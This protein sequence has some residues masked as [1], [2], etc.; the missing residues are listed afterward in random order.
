VV[1]NSLPLFPLG[2]VLYPGGQLPLQI[3]E[4]RYLD[5]MKK[6]I[7]AGA[8][9]GVV[10]LTQGGEVRGPKN[11]ESFADVG[12]LATVDS[13]QAP[14]P[15]L[16]LVHCIGAQRY[17]I[18]R[19]EQLKHGLWIADVEHIAAD[20]AVK[21]PQELLHCTDLLRKIIQAL[22]D[23]AQEYY[24]EA[25]QDS[26]DDCAWVAHRWCELLPIPT[27]LKQRMLELDNPVIRLELI[28]DMLD[29]FQL[30]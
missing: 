9:F 12:T 22:P 5:M 1:L 8:P 16:I 27:Q 2:T 15:G 7:Q 13:H 23:S 19:R 17:R 6:C 20:Q 4:V 26:Y 10:A 11:H 14:Q 30:I 3:F 25:P 18:T 29:K 21:I 24:L 28:S